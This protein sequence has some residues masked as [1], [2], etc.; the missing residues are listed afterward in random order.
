MDKL[1]MIINGTALGRR[2]QLSWKNPEPV[3]DLKR[4]WTRIPELKAKSKEANS[5]T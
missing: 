5:D 1:N 3:E 2:V 4:G